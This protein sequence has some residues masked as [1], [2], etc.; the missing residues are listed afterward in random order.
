MR[1]DSVGDIVREN[2]RRNA[3]IFAKT[4]PVT[5]EASVCA[6]ERAELELPGFPIKKQWIPVSMLK[7]PLI[8]KLKEC[9]SLSAFLS[10]LG[11]D[12]TEDNRQSVVRAFVGLRCL[13]D[14]A[15]WAAVLVYIKNK[16]GG[17]DCLF[18]LTRPQRRFVLRLEK[19]R[20]AGMPIR[21]VLLKARQW[22]GST[23]SQLY[24]AWLQLVHKT[25]LN[26]LIIAH[27]GSASDEIKEMFNRM[28]AAYPVWMLH[29]VSEAYSD[30]EPKLVGVGHS[31]S[32]SRVPQRN[33][34]IK[35][36]TAERPDACRG[37]DY[38]LVHLS[39]V[40][41]WKATDG[42]K[43]PEDIVR[44][45]CAGVL[46][47][48]YTMIVY[49]STANGTGN[50]FH[51]EYIAAKCR[52]SQFEAVFIA[53]YDIDLYR[54]EF[55][56]A[57][58]KE[59]FAKMLLERRN[60]ETAP[61]DR[62]ECGKYLWWL[63]EKGA[64]LEA[65]AWYIDERKKYNDHGSMAAENPT[66]D[67]EAFVHSGHRVF[68][69]YQIEAM[70]PMCKPPQYTG[71][72]V[73]DGDEGAKALQ[74]IRFVK[75]TQGRL[76]VWD[77]PEA[78][79]GDET[80]RDRY[81]VCVDVGG[82]WHKADWSVIAVFDR[83]FMIDGDRPCV[84]AQWYGHTDIDILAWKAAQIAKW[85]NNALLVIESN[86]VESKEAVTEGDQSL[87]IFNQIKAVYDNLY[88]REPSEDDIREGR[89]RK[90]GFHTN[91]KTKREIISN[92]VKVIRKKMYVERDGRCL[93][94]YTNYEQKQNLSYGAIPGEHDDILMTRAIGLHICF[95]QMP[96]PRI[97]KKSSVQMPKPKIVSAATL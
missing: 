82:R 38:N 53:W 20:L 7:S 87:F 8:R 89:P 83:L 14:F 71:G 11:E 42:G 10:D 66:D 19:L 33:C 32:I 60:S 77:M 6:E 44:A 40:G 81:L 73:A 22:G 28:I 92:L 90:Y 13:H 69:K 17:E 63:W 62:E 21:I 94:E 35:I 49:E 36:G 34:N 23:T 30:T 26:S 86:T 25:G 97:V 24:M 70:R 93:D 80:V 74:G 51:K 55:A 37:G 3:V 52:R 41:L 46:Y 47:K 50:F 31:G 76:S 54:K 5:G 29:Q 96:L 43:K 2:D 78:D 64:T 1:Y 48:P 65:I 75:D 27:Q 18:R 57:D 67:I 88:A 15:F 72:L 4:N 79:A 84:V 95:N 61:S 39:E 9:G 85:Y 45:A 59:A 58:E 68:D 16:G 91:V 56:N 12:D